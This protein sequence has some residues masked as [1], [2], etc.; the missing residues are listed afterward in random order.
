MSSSEPLRVQLSA[1]REFLP[2]DTAEQKLF[3]MLKLRPARAVEAAKPATAFVFLIDTSGSMYEIVDG[4]GQR[5]GKTITVDGQQYNETVGG[6]T[7]IDIVIESL[8]TLVRS[9]NLD[10]NDKVAIVQF[11]DTAST[12]I[13][14]T[15]ATETDKLEAAI[16]QLRRHSGGTEMAKGMRQTL[17]I[18]ANQ[19]GMASRRAL[20]FTDGV[21]FDEEECHTLSP[22]FA[23]Q[24]IPI[25]SLGVGEYNEDLLLVLS[26]KSGGRVFHVADDSG[27][28]SVAINDLPQ[29]ITEE[30]ARAQKDVIT[31]LALS[32]K[33]VKGVRLQRVLRAYPDVAEFP[34]EAAPYPIGNAAANDETVFIMEFE[35]DSRPTSR[36]RVAQIGL[37]YDVPGQNRRGELTPQNLIVQFVV[38]QGGAAQ[39]DQEVMQYMQQ[40]NI[41]K[42]VGQATAVADQDPQKAQELLETAHRMTVRIGN[43]DLMESLGNAKDELRKTK[44]ISAG[45]RKTVKMG[46]KGKTVNMSGDI[47]EGLSEDEIRAVSG[48]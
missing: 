34:V 5:T 11:D 16:N 44:K 24:N 14:L 37:T 25:T 21:T 35:L 19:M 17:E 31:N 12:L 23:T 8:L 2:A 18:F 29:T 4:G 7:K 15:P 48:T 9:G 30:F 13:E 39:V 38:D 3:V 26:D 46:A 42:I 28:S 20:I 43:A 1:H 47:N 6:T 22:E 36:A 33:T 32:A 40:C 27:G 41:S 10:A 45:T